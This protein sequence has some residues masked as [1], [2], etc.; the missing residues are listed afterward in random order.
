MMNIVLSIRLFDRVGRYFLQ[1][2][3]ATHDRAALFIR[4]LCHGRTC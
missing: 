2:D 4:T 1:T 3:L